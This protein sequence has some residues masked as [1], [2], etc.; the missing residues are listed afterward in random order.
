MATSNRRGEA[1]A[2][3]SQGRATPGSTRIGW[4]GTGVMGSS[5]CGHLLAAGFE[6]T[7]TNRTRPKAE[8]LLE[9]GARWVG[10]PQRWRQ[11]VTSSSRWSA[12]P[13]T[14]ERCSLATPVPSAVR[15]A[16]AIMIDMTT[17]EP[18]LAREVARRAADRDVAVLDAPVSGGDVGAR[19]ASLSIMIG[20]PQSTAD[21]VMPCFEAMGTTIVR[22]GDHG[23]GQHAELVNQILIASTMVAMSEGLLYAH[24]QGL[25]VVQVLASVSTGAA[26]SWALSNLAPRVVAGDFAP[27]F[28][29]DHLV[30]DLGIA[31]AEA[32]RADLVL[33]GLALAHQLYEALQAQGRGREGTQALVGALGVPSRPALAAR[34]GS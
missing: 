34:S 17:S 8:G 33:P 1:V 26:G 18:S 30:K 11:R 14:C 13:R 2:P 12:C 27:G 22:Q 16:E 25:D 24:R 3:Q 28:T 29:V 31:L 23:A 4:I 32:A 20:G 7:V 10:T 21:V 19:D 15:R 5:M 9:R 6:V